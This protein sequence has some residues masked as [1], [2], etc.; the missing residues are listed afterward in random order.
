M[1]VP[2]IYQSLQEFAL[3]QDGRVIGFTLLCAF[4]LLWLDRARY[5]LPLWLGITTGFSIFV[6]LILPPYIALVVI[7]V[8]VFSTLM[9]YLMA[10][11]RRTHA[12]Q[13]RT[14]IAWA[15]LLFQILLVLFL[16]LISWGAVYQADLVW[17][18]ES[19]DATFLV[20]GLFILGGFRF[21][22]TQDPLLLGMGIL[23][24]ITAVGTWQV[25]TLQRP[26]ALAIWSIL[27]LLTVLLTNYLVQANDRIA[28]FEQTQLEEGTSTV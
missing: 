26:L 20:I 5:L 28:T 17:I 6:S 24:V 15:T 9:L 13:A 16:L 27:V 19:A 7:V 25:E 22:T 11:N 14:M 2:A 12:P 21:F 4:L 10:R 3:F 1:N 8:G 23:L 18:G